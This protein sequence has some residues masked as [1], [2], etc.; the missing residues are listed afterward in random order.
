MNI[1][2]NSAAA[3]AA[4][5]IEKA[6][7]VTESALHKVVRVH[8][9]SGIER[10]SE[11]I[12]EPAGINGADVGLQFGTDPATGERVVRVI[13]KR[14]GGVVRQGPPEELLNVMQS[15]RALKGLLLSTK[16]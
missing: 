10:P 13:D 8:G 3:P 4:I 6:G 16:S 5:N 9:T 14:T 12:V 1:Q 15:L 7:S 2:P 11:S